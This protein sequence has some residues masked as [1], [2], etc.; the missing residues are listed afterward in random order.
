MPLV[1]DLNTIEI[2]IYSCKSNIHFKKRISKSDNKVESS[3]MSNL[4]Q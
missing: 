4:G 3:L 2:L 1:I